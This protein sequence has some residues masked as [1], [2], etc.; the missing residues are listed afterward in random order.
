M[1]EAVGVRQSKSGIRRKAG[2]RARSRGSVEI[3]MYMASKASPELVAILEAF[4]SQGY[5][6][7]GGPKNFTTKCP[8]HDD[9]QPSLSIADGDDKVV[10]K[11]HGGC[12]QKELF[13]AVV[14]FTGL[15]KSAFFFTKKSGPA[16]SDGPVATV[17]E[18]A[19][20]KNLPVNLMAWAGWQ[21]SPQGIRIPYWTGPEQPRLRV[22]C[23]LVAKTGSYWGPAPYEG[24]RIPAYGAWR[25]QDFRPGRTVYLV[26]GETDALTGWHYGLPVLGIPGKMFARNVLAQYPQLLEGID[27]IFVIEEPDD[28]ATRQFLKGVQRGLSDIHSKAHILPMRLPEKDLSDLHVKRGPEGLKHAFY[29]SWEAAEDVP[30]WP[31]PMPVTPTV[32]RVLAVLTTPGFPPVFKIRD[33]QRRA[34][35]LPASK[36]RTDLEVLR[37]AHIVRMLAA[38]RVVGRPAVTYKI[39]PK[40]GA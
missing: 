23:G 27:K 11:C 8:R 18:L 33:F 5:G 6:V 37:Q 40:I 28:Y 38:P 9:E 25:M 26:E 14:E 30:N 13:E 15:G 22:R 10:L 20:L 39:N 17:A 24:H 4:K 34:R 16:P 36:I 32:A 2:R 31:D 21:D 35:D 19:A 7:G 3:D 29:A 1:G 12:L